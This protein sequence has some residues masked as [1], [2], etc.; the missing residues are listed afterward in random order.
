MH[1]GLFKG[2]LGVADFITG[3]LDKYP[4]ELLKGR[5]TVEG[6]VIACIMK[7]ILLLDEANLT[8]RDFITEDGVFYFGL[9][10]SIRDK[11]FNSIDEITIL[12]S[13]GEVVEQGFLNRGGWDTIQN[14]VDTI[15]DKNWDQYI[16]ILYREN[17][18]IKLYNDGFNILSEVEVDTDNKIVA[19]DLFRKM[20]SEGV[21]DFYESRLALLTNGSNSKILEEGDLEI[22]DQFLDDLQ[23]GSESGIP[24]D[25][26]GID[27]VDGDEVK[28]LPFLSN[29]V[30][31]F[32]EGTLNMVGGFSS[33]GKTTIWVTMMMS[34]ASQGRKILIVTNEQK[35]TVFKVQF[36]TWLLAKKFK[37]YKITKRKLKNRD[38]L[39]DEDRAML[40]K[41]QILWNEEFKPQ[42]KFIQIADADI[43]VVKK[44]IRQ[45]A[46]TL[47]FDTF[48]Y[49]TFKLDIDNM[50][51]TAR[52]DIGLIKDSRELDKIAKKY[53]MIGLASVQLAESLNGTLFL[54]A[55]VLSNCKQIKEILETLLLMRT[56]YSEELDKDNKK[57]YCKPFVRKKVGDKWV[58][59]PYEADTSAVYR[60]IFPEKNRNGESS[61]D[62]GVAHLLKFDGSK[63]IFFE[64]ALC[65][66]KHGSISK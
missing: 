37:Y 57:L 16:D 42:F 45:Y 46:L 38:E 52:T 54:N 39:T 49:D 34:L 2:G 51:A 30:G 19:L 10:K 5:V 17:N 31:G 50:S 3:V 28:C 41:A 63:G 59:E 13:V 20:D 58:E 55:S 64:K 8:Y 4:K 32:L 33:T 40:K 66:P 43:S 27:E 44:K 29:Q 15:N 21:I 6:N 60:M 9:A 12:S 24:F 62:T 11:G 7:D 18:I 23:D 35:S 48:L 22:T 61:N 53:N 26:C 65:R 1:H 47:G 36:I 14:L 56:V 25:Y